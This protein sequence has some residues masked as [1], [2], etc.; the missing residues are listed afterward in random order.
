VDDRGDGE[1]RERRRIGEGLVFAALLVAHLLPLVLLPRIPTQDGP[2]H[3]ALARAMAVLDEPAGEPLRRWFVR[4]PELVPNAFLFHA[5][6]ALLRALPAPLVEKV[7][8]AG[9][10][11]LLPLGLLF[12]LRSVSRDGAFLA[13]L[14]FPFV[15]NFLTN[16]GFLNF[17]YALAGFLFAL[18]LLLRQRQARG[19]RRTA[20]VA[21]LALVALAIYA[22]HPVP[23]VVLVVA[24]V[25]LGGWWSLR[26][27]RRPEQPPSLVGALRAELLAPL[28]A[29]VPAVVLFV[30]FLDSRVER[31]MR[32]EPIAETARQL[33]TLEV[34]ASMDR[35][36]VWVA[37]G[38]VLLLAVLVVRQAARRVAARRPG[39][40]W[41]AEGLLLLA[42]ACVAMVLVCPDDIAG[43]G[44][45]VD[46]LTLFP[47]LVLLAWLAGGRWGKG[48]RWAVM[49]A[50]V[51]LSAAL[52]GLSW[53]RWV[54][55]N[56]NL[57]DYLAVASQ[58]E[59]GRAAVSVSL[60][61][62]VRGP[63]GLFHPYRVFPYVHAFG[64]V[65]AEGGAAAAHAVVNHAAEPKAKASVAAAGAAAAHAVVN[66]G[67]YEATTDLFPLRFRAEVDPYNHLAARPG[68]LEWAPPAV[69]LLG[70][71]R[72]TGARVDYVIVFQPNFQLADERQ[73]N[74]LYRQLE[75]GFERTAVSPRGLAE[76]WRHR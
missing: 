14:G 32:W 23:L 7:M 15:Y 38:M 13:A 67:Q 36:T 26:A 76:L 35:R 72:R 41:P 10:V 11:A 75:E 53:G 33:V 2:S 1:R 55:V 31:Y 40:V 60:S 18:G 25:T 47:P 69:D 50:A 65:A 6:A 44:F 43:G 62:Q 71:E 19:W 45:V 29:L 74:E 46:R 28:A 57:D 8:M 73:V 9:Y 30:G 48:E 59:P 34:L 66:L 24:A 21:L 12:A 51:L 37:A 63:D 54:E 27:V 42:F 49:G 68:G 52:L 17:G 5:E 4:N 20:R 39:Q 3:Q 58:V 16:L 22:C 70:F 56:A 61:H 64:Y